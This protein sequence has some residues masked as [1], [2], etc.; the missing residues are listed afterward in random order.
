MSVSKW[1]T[2][3]KIENTK[4][5][6]PYH[7]SLCVFQKTIFLKVEIIEFQNVYYSTD[8]CLNDRMLTGFVQ[9]RAIYRRE[10]L[11]FFYSH[12]TSDFRYNFFTT[13]LSRNENLPITHIFHFYR[14]HDIERPTSQYHIIYTA[15]LRYQFC[16]K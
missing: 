16:K 15:I 8:T 11:V 1:P 4:I 14:S 9:I 10:F 5:F 13:Y 2:K 6:S 12:C 3:K 7:R